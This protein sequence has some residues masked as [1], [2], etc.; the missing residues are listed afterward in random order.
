MTDRRKSG[1]MVLEFIKDRELWDSFVDASTYGLL[2]HKWDYITITAQHA[3]Y[4]LL[5]PYGIYK[6]EELVCLA[7]LYL[8]STHGGVKILFS[9]P[10]MQAVVPPYQGFVPGKSFDTLKLGKK[11]EIMDL[12]A[13][14]ISPRRSMPSHRITSP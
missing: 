1:S 5:P 4:R 13:G 3:G 12:V 14:G 7:P 2:F 8:K 6:G 11:E 9:P 10:P